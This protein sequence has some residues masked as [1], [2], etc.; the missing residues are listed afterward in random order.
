MQPEELNSEG[1]YS[2]RASVPSPV[3][4]VL[5]ANMNETEL[6]PIV[7]DMWPNNENVTNANWNDLRANAVSYTHLTLPTKRIV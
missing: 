3:L 7:Y 6:A 2:L 1:T 4:N 5:C